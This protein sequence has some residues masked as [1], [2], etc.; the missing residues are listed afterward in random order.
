MTSFL[1]TA[2]SLL[3]VS[4]EVARAAL[5]IDDDDTSKDDE[6]STFIAGVTQEL[7]DTIGQCI[8]PQAWRVKG[9]DFASLVLPHP[10]TT[11][12]SIGYRD[13]SGTT[14]SLATDQ[15]RVVIERYASNL[16]A[17]NGVTLPV[18]DGA[19]DA[20]TVDV[21]VGMATSQ[22]NV[23]PAIVLYV[24]QRLKQQ[25]DPAARLERDT[26]QSNYIETLIRQFKVKP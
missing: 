9:A 14:Q 24:K 16:V 13:A 26:V 5:R 19:A 18:T 11:V 3:P 17:A 22:D 7:E 4:L 15:V 12:T 23:P 10:V 2:P 8:M 20:V 6:I 21:G 25:F 1:V